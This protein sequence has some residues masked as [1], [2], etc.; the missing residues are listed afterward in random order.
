MRELFDYQAD[1]GLYLNLEGDREEQ[2]QQWHDR[3][4]AESE[5]EGFFDEVGPQGRTGLRAV[6]RT[7][8][9]EIPHQFYDAS[10]R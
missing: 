8:I 9:S 4:W 2:Y 6:P 1:K 7:P 3:F 5:L 10:K